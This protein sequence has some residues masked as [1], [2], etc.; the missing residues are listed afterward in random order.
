[1]IAVYYDELG[2][3]VPDPGLVRL[4]VVDAGLDS[5]ADAGRQFTAWID[6]AP[7]ISS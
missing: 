1:V 7:A 4:G 6:Q 3:A 2:Q 5:L